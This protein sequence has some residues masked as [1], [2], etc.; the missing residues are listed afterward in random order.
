M[1]EGVEQ[2]SPDD[3]M[4]LETPADSVCHGENFHWGTTGTN[5]RLLPPHKVASCAEGIETF[6]GR[7]QAGKIGC[8]YFLTSNMLYF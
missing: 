5:C 3:V 7:T 2:I 6:C 1:D 4:V 8:F